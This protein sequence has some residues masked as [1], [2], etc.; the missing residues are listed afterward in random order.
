MQNKIAYNLKKE[1]KSKVELPDLYTTQGRILIPFTIDLFKNIY[2]VLKD[3]LGLTTDVAVCNAI[4]FD[5]GTLSS[6]NKGFLKKNFKIKNSIK[7]FITKGYNYILKYHS[8][9]HPFIES[10][11]C[12]KRK[13]HKPN[14]WFCDGQYYGTFQ[15]HD[16]EFYHFI[17]LINGK[18]VTVTS[19]FGG[20]TYGRIEENQDT[21]FALLS[22][23]DNTITNFFIGLKFPND[24]NERIF[25]ATWYTAKLS[26]EHYINSALCIAVY[27]ENPTYKTL[28]DIEDARLIS[29]KINK[30]LLHD[31]MIAKI[32]HEIFD[33][34]KRKPHNHICQAEN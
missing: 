25:I 3:D 19:E 26:P 15:R 31:E 16:K 21:Y 33:K 29:K 17:M 8:D 28:R 34:L 9:V 2:E 27:V 30:K 18:N 10:K 23:D 5:N 14:Q 1:V 12:F 6:I 13:F 32:D 7:A 24:P 4:G 22:N 20:I 11:L